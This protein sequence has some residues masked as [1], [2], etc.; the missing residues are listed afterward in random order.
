MKSKKTGT[1]GQK[2]NE[3]RAD[4]ED[5]VTKGGVDVQVCLATVQRGSDW[6]II[7]TNSHLFSKEAD[8][9]KKKALHLHFCSFISFSQRFTELSSPHIHKPVPLQVFQVLKPVHFSLHSPQSIEVD[10]HPL[11]IP[12]YN[13]YYGWEIWRYKTVIDAEALTIQHFT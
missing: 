10:R 7:Y 5:S 2:K 12:L 6:V 8:C 13:Y 4:T 11:Y 3:G 1:D 9:R